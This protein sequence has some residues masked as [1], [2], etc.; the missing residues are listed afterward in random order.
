M[1]LRSLRI[2]ALT[3][4]VALLA[5][6]C[7]SSDETADD[8]AGETPDSA[9]T[10]STD[11]ADPPPTTVLDGTQQAPPQ[12]T[13]QIVE[14]PVVDGA[15]DGLVWTVIAVGFGDSLNVREDPSPDAPIVATLEPWATGVQVSDDLVRTD[16]G[17]W[18]GVTAPG[19]DGSEA[20]GWVNARFLV[21]QP[22]DF[23]EADATGT[24]DLTSDV[25]LWSLGVD[26]D[27]PDEWL[28]DR[29]LWVGGIGVYA[30]FPWWNWIPAIE[31]AERDGW[32]ADQRFEPPPDPDG[33]TFDCGS[34]CT[35]TLVE[36]LLFDRLAIDVNGDTD[37]DL[38]PL[39][40]SDPAIENGFTDGPFVD[41]PGLHRIVIDQPSSTFTAEDGT[42]QPA[43]DW[44]RISLVYDW[45]EGRDQGPR[46]AM[47]HTWG[48][49]P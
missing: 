38:S 43:L 7:T 35:K 27:L 24:R 42:E 4:L 41:A 31:V 21:A 40:V 8:T 15:V 18:R 34:D 47:I 9:A 32:T 26:R 11:T 2:V 13:G 12:T 39:L 45:S 22:A 16:A 20:R 1:V 14:E 5:A 25:V 29:A 28:A 17:T 37:V 3:V 19:V 33:A 44:L 6:A 10:V 46:L 30:D 23:D 49:T 48:W 36:Y